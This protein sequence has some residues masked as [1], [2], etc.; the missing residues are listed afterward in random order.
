MIFITIFFFVF[1][2]FFRSNKYPPKR[3]R[4]APL[5]QKSHPSFFSLLPPSFQTQK[6]HTK[7]SKAK[8]KHLFFLYKKNKKNNENKII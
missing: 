5:F 8:V 1:L 7:T 4:Q 2:F 6:Q 3:Q